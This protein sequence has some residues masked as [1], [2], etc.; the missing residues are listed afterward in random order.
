MAPRKRKAARRRRPTAPPAQF[1]QTEPRFTAATLR[2][3]VIQS[4]VANNSVKSLIKELVSELM[5]TQQVQTTNL[6]VWVVRKMTENENAPVAALPPGI[7]PGRP[8][9]ECHNFDY[10]W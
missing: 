4:A 5:E 6:L 8:S 2:T 7:P 3:N 1:I 9:A 10:G